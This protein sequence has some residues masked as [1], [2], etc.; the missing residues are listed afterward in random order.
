MSKL[1]SATTHH[2]F[3][4]SCPQASLFRLIARAI[5]QGSASTGVVLSA[6]PVKTSY[7]LC[8]PAILN[9]EDSGEEKQTRQRQSTP[10]V[11]RRDWRR[12]RA[13]V[14]QY[15]YRI[16]DVV[17]HGQIGSAIFVEITY[18]QFRRPHSEVKKLDR[19]KRS[20]SSPEQNCDRVPRCL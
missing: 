15:G 6:P 3:G 18:A 16:G 13:L 12:R 2:G 8:C 9:D 10:P 17:H 5:T 11:Q 14:Y 7:L 1:S 20:V 19:L 4:N